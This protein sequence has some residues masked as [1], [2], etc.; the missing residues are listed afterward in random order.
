MD[1]KELD[2]FRRFVLYN[3]VWLN[4]GNLFPIK[5]LDFR[6]AQKLFTRGYKSPGI[7]KDV[8]CIGF[9]EGRHFYYGW[10]LIGK[11]NDQIVRFHHRDKVS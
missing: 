8:V 1:L 5:N 4:I 10:L 2:F 9:V 11:V 6:H 3:E 7:I